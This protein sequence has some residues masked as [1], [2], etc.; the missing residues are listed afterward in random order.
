MRYSA[1]IRERGGVGY[2]PTSGIPFVHVDTSRVRHWPRMPRDELALLFPSGHSKHEPA[3]GRPITPADVKAARE[4]SKDVA[5]EVA[6]FY[7]L[8]DSPKTATRVASL[9]APEPKPAPR[10]QKAFDSKMAVGAPTPEDMASVAPEAL[11]PIIAPKLIAEPKP[12]DRPSRF[13]KAVPAADR[14]R[15]DELVSLAS[16]GEKPAAPAAKPPRPNFV[17]ASASAAPIKLAALE[18][19]D[20]D[21][22]GGSCSD[23]RRAATQ[24]GSRLRSSTRTIRKSFRIGPS[25]WRRC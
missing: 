8:R 21:A 3:D 18:P 12:I 10:P 11:P 23:R 9:T 15:L 7:A 22:A 13:A 20:P 6:Q 5:V 14:T 25:R 4:R 16:L 24:R 17:G 1:M 19:Y 2:Y